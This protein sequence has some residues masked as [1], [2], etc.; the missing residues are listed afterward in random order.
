MIIEKKSGKFTTTAICNLTT[1]QY[2]HIH[3]YTPK[4][5]RV[6]K[7]DWRLSG[8]HKSI[9]RSSL[10]R[11]NVNV[12]ASDRERVVSSSIFQFQWIV[13]LTVF[14]LSRAIFILYLACFSSFFFYINFFS[15][16]NFFPVCTWCWVFLFSFHLFDGAPFRTIGCVC[17]ATKKNPSET[18]KWPLI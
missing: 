8:E 13:C 10:I 4:N 1:I 14:F 12:N 3:S 6:N 7:C 17:G 16:M 11:W 9:G 15:T 18:T 5:R 2:T